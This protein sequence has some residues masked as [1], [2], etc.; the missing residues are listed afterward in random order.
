[1]ALTDHEWVCPLMWGRTR[2][3]PAAVPKLAPKKEH[4]GTGASYQAPHGTRSGLARSSGFPIDV[5]VS[6]VT[7]RKGLNQ[8]RRQLRS[9]A[10]KR[11]ERRLA[12][13]HQGSG[14]TRRW[15]AS[16]QR[17]DRNHNRGCSLKLY[18]L[19]SFLG[20]PDSQ[21]LA[22]GLSAAA[23]ALRGT[24]YVTDGNTM[25]SMSKASVDKVIGSFPVHEFSGEL[26]WQS[27]LLG[28]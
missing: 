26:R 17:H 23:S 4:L 27:G 7:T 13:T 15:L 21:V 18:G 22:E 5:S 12:G 20:I 9:C 1:M 8:A 10:A 16:A 28:G 25:L 3:A 19:A 6:R 11:N 24:V 14:T 2:S